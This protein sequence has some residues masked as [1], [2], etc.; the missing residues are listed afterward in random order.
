MS[1]P[2]P[3]PPIDPADDIRS[4]AVH[5]KAIALGKLAI[6]AT[7]SAG[8]GHPTTALS[9]AHLVTVLMYG[10][11]RW[12]PARPDAPGSDRLVLSEGHAVPIVYAACTDLGVT[13]RPGGA[14]RP[15]TL[16]DLLA[17]RSIDSFVDG[18]PNPMLGFPFFDAAT[19]SLGQGLS[20]A[21]GLAAA[22]RIDGS[23][24]AI[25]C[26]IGDGEAREGQIWEAMDFIADHGLSSVVALFNCN[27]LGQSDRVSPAQDWQ[28]LARKAEA[29][30]W[31]AVVVDG[32][33][34]VAIEQVLR[35]RP[36]SREARPLCVI[37]R[38][39]KGWGVPDLGGMGHH[40]TPVTAG[41]LDAALAALDARARALGVAG[42]DPGA[43]A[44]VLTIAPPPAPPASTPAT[45]PVGF[46]AAV[47]RNPTVAAAVKEKRALSPRRAYGLALEALGAANPAVVALDADVK[48]STYA[49]G[50]AKAFP[51]RYF[52]ARI[53]EQ[54]MVSAAAGLASGG[55]IP[56]ASTFG[57]FLERAFDQIEMA[58]IG[59]AGL[60]LVG[61]HAGATLASDGPSQMA[62]ADVA[63]MR[64]FS[65]VEDKAGR[66]AVTVLTP[67][68]A[69]GAY[70]MVLAMARSPGAF[71][72]RAV[73]ADLPILYAEDDRF[74]FGGHKVLRCS[75]NDGPRM[76]L[77]ASGYMVHGCLEAAEVLAK[78]G[79]SVAV[80]DAY[81]LP[82]GTAPVLA[83]AGRG[84]VVMTVED[85]YVGGIGSELAEAA[86]EAVDA[87]RVHALAVRTMP[88]SGRTPND[89]LA[90]V[91]LGVADIV[92]AVEAAARNVA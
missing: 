74:P 88:K 4:K 55:K 45:E 57:R 25:Y 65:H 15:M 84:G 18:H 1:M 81:C 38:T 63:F 26:I 22:A 67:S 12:D 14:A 50:F 20:V 32:H 41:G 51:E 43:S 60:K 42:I 28:S 66:P 70:A 9:L 72:L 3:V 17:L 62:L 46:M 91:R 76:V 58:V 78:A 10:V 13:V 77:V 24:K 68:D 49:D 23:A 47:G 75:P 89:V 53:A 71:Y 64:A 36:T 37:A 39:V 92:S 59:G 31:E 7:T 29:F 80:V 21:A 82:M 30:G 16:D 48:N 87:P 5:A 83:L 6:R 85:N 40:G 61:T 11:M 54:N 8:S 2:A 79:H 33:D 27:A 52:E 35:A 69:V 73:R 90:Y 34:P 19:G 56:F 44:A 86:A